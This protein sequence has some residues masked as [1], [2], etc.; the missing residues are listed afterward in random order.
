MFIDLCIYDIIR[1]DC[2]LCVYIDC[3]F[4]VM[5]CIIKLYKKK[6]MKI[7]SIIENVK[8]NFLV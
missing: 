5:F 7:I 3:D 4:G 2:C 6:M 8:F 1:F